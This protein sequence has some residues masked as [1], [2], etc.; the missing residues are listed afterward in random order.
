MSETKFW[1][2]VLRSLKGGFH[3]K[4]ICLKKAGKR[5]KS[6][7]TGHSYPYVGHQISFLL[8]YTGDLI[9][10]LPPYNLKKGTIVCMHFF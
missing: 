1:L 4:W 6:F 10:S 3:E 7:Q 5:V 9:S 2:K 8:K